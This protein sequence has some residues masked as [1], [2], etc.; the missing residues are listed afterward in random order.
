F[1][2]AED[3]IRDRNVTGVQTCALPILVASEQPTHVAVAF[4][5]PG[6]TFRDRIYDQYKAGRDE[7]PP[8]FVGQI[9]LIKQV[10][11]AMGVA[12]LT[13]EDYEGD[14]IIAT[15]STRTATEGGTALIVS[16]DRDAV[17]LVDDRVTLLQPIKGVTEMRRMTPAAVEEKYGVAPER[18]PDLAA[19]V[20]ESADNLPGVPGVGPKTAAKWITLYG[21]LPGIIAHAEEIKGKAGQSLRDHLDEVERNRRM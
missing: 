4:D 16:S 17:Q 10:L 7:S 1:F 11:D 15:L 14:D 18:Y 3:G 2:Q 12:W 6:G 20:G 21:D 19:L 8:E 5:L 13:V 9:D